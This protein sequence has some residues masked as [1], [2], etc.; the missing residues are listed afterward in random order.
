MFAFIAL[1]TSTFVVKA[2]VLAVAVESDASGLALELPAPM[3]RDIPNDKRER[4]ID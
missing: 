2:F 3:N 1:A 4:R